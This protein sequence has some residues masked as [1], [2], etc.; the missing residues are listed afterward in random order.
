[1]V[2]LILLSIVREH[3]DATVLTMCACLA[4]FTDVMTTMKH[5]DQS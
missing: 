5:A 1:M 3:L 4:V 2:K